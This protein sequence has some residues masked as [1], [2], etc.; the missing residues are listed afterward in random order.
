MSGAEVPPHKRTFFD[1]CQ[2]YLFVCQQSCMLDFPHLLKKQEWCPWCI[3]CCSAPKGK[4]E[5]TVG[6]QIFCFCNCLIEWGLFSFNLSHTKR[7]IVSKNPDIKASNLFTYKCFTCG[8]AKTVKHMFMSFTLFGRK[9]HFLLCIV[10][11]ILS[12]A[13]FSS[14]KTYFNLTTLTIA[15]VAWQQTG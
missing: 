2:Y 3:L 6:W 1:C 13:A 8:S 4:L 11:D 5:E 12:H 10:C 14:D 15:T 7:P 9:R